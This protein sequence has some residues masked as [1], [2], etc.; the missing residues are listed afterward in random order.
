MT[1]TSQV[2]PAAG[3]D[4]LDPLSSGSPKLNFAFR[5][6]N[7]DTNNIVTTSFSNVY[8]EAFLKNDHDNGTSSNVT[9]PIVNCSDYKDKIL[10]HIPAVDTF[11]IFNKS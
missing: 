2:Q 3:D 11:H 7:R 5:L 6:L 1:F 10:K 9:I 4:P 8:F